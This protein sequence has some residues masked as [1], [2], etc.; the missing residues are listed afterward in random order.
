MNI[1]HSAR[2]LTVSSQDVPL[3]IKNEFIVFK[4]RAAITRGRIL[5]EGLEIYAPVFDLSAN[6]EKEMM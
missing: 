2:G 4:G 6:I 3:C 5:G 1:T